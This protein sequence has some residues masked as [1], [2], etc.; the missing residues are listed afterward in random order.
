MNHYRFPYIDHINDVL[1]VIKDSPEFT[2]AERGDHTI[3]N[4]NVAFESTFPPVPAEW[5]DPAS[6]DAMIRREC[7]G[8]IFDSKTGAVIAR[9]LHK[10]FNVGE[11]EETQPHN[12][13]FNQPHWILEKLDG[14][15]ITPYYVNNVLYWGTKMGQT[16][17]GRLAEAFVAVNPQYNRFARWA[18]YDRCTLIFEFVSRDQRIV[19]DYPED[20]LVLIAI[21]N[22]WSGEYWEYQGIASIAEQFGVPVVKQYEGTAKNIQQLVEHTRG[23][24]GQEGF[25][26]RFK[27]GHMVKIKSEWYVNL[28]KTKDLIRYERNLVRL[29]FDNQ[30]DDLKQFLDA[31]DFSR[32]EKY[33]E[34]FEYDIKQFIDAAVKH[35]D[36]V[37][38]SGIDRKTYA[39]TTALVVH[40]IIKTMVFKLWDRQVMVADVE[41]ILVDQIRAH[42][43]TN[44]KFEELRNMHV[45]KTAQWNVQELEA[46]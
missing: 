24:K 46:A 45:I 31:S 36:R 2:V 29:I 35:L 41:Q 44:V 8:I 34:L 11:R 23:L 19:V 7:R 30:I 33:C 28:H 25:V 5:D 37:R 13:D 40:P 32:V 18:K 6:Y 39:L 1:E 9:R 14:S 21:R 38:E 22:N 43:S 42:L 26:V 15:M 4:Y 12:I 27:S 16:D 20:Q 17:V 3:I 10:F